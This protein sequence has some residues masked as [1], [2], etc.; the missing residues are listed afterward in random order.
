MY[1]WKRF[2]CLTTGNIKLDYGGFLE[3]PESEYA[4][5]TNSDVFPFSAISHIPCLVLLGEP[6]IGK[7]TAT[8]QAYEQVRD[9]VPKLKDTCLW[10]KLGDYESDKDLC[11]AIFRNET[12]ASW[13]HGNH[14]LHLF[15][16]SLDE[17][18]LS[19][20]ILIRILKR[21]IE[22][23]PCE[24]L[25]FRITCR[26]SVWLESSS[27]EQK[28]KEKW[29]KANTGIYE[30]APLRRKDVIEATTA[31]SVN[32]NEFIQEILDREATPL[33]IKPVTLKFL[34]STY[35][36]N[37]QLPPSQKELYEQGCLHLCEEVN[38][39]RRESGFKGKL[40]S[41]QRLI[42]AGR[43]A[44]VM[45]FANRAAIWTSPELA[46]MPNSAIAILDLCV[47]EESINQQEFL[48]EEDSVRE[49]LSITGLF[50]SRG[51]NRMGF[52]HQTYAE[53]LAAWYLVQHEIPLVQ[54]MSSVVSPEDPE[55]KLV[56]QLHE[57]A[58]WLAGMMPDVFREIMKADPDVL[59]RSDVATADVKDREALVENLLKL[60]DEEK[61]PNGALGN[62]NRYRKLEHPG[63]VE[64]L[65]PYIR[66][67]NKGFE[68]RYVAIDIAEACELQALQDD[69]ADVALDTSQALR[70]RL[71]AVSAICKIGNEEVK[72]RLKP[73]AIGEAKDN[74]EVDLK[75]YALQAVWPDHLKAEELFS[76][77]T[78]SKSLH[79]KFIFGDFVRHLQPVDLSLALEWVEK[80]NPIHQS[81]EK[82]VDAIMLK[83]WEHLESPGVLKALAKVA[84]SQL[85]YHDEIM[86]GCHDSLFRSALSNDDE[87]RRQVLEAMLS[88]LSNLES[89]L[90]LLAHTSTPII[91]SRDIPWL[92]ERLQA[93][94]SEQA[95]K[96]WA[97]LIRCVF[98]S[99]EQGHSDAVIVASQSN[100]IVAEAFELYLK[101]IALDSPQA[102]ELRSE[103]L[104]TQ[105]RRSRSQ[106]QRQPLLEPPPAERIIALLDDFESGNL[107]AWWD[108]PTQMMLRPDGT[109]DTHISERDLTGLP[110]WNTAEAKT[111]ARFVEAAKKYVLE[112]E[113]ETDSLRSST[114]YHS[115]LLG[116]QTLRLLLKEVPSFVSS[117]SV[118]V[119]KKW[120]PF[121][122]CY[123]SSSGAKEEE[124]DYHLLKMT[125]Q[126]APTE[127]INTLILLIDKE[128]EEHN[129]IFINCNFEGCWDERLENALLTK[130]KDNK[131]KPESMGYLLKYLLDHAVDKA[132][133]FAESIIPLQPSSLEEKQ[134]RAFV[135]ASVL[136]THAKD[137]GWSVVWPA[138]QQDPEFGRKVVEDV[139][140]S[141]RYAVNVGQALSED[142]LA[143]L[144]V[145]LVHQ[146][147]YA[148]DPKHE[149]VYSPG[150]RDNIAK[151]RNA[152]LRLLQERGTPQ[153]C[154]EIQEIINKLPEI[155]GLK[156]VLL[157]AQT[158][159]RRRTWKPP[160]P[161]EI[162]QLVSNKEKRLIQD[163]NELLDV[164][165]ESLQNLQV[166]LQGETPAVIDLWNEIKWGQIRSLAD[167]LVKY[168]KRQFGLDKF[169]KIDVWKEV[170]WR[171]ITDS[172]YL[173]KD[174]NRFSDYVVRYLK[175]NLKER[176]VIVNREVEI[177][178]G[179]RTDIQVDAVRKKPNGDVYDS[180]TVIIEVKGCW[181]DELNSAMEI[182]LVNRYLKDNTCQHGVYLV[183][184]FNCEQWDNSDSRKSKAPKISIDEAREKFEKQAEQLSQL[185]IKVKAFVL[186][187]ALR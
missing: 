107:T 172:A 170:N 134:A 138:I 76:A 52:A 39:D 17:G 2:W 165:L 153:A 37:G 84:L 64:Q 82:L 42:T 168:L 10:F 13:L 120:A 117:I 67:L 68:A 100:S 69:L 178:R 44:A 50:S 161:S 24:R 5:F 9:Q 30:L 112:E 115:S 110:G 15:L 179:E 102:Q 73:L 139:S 187:T 108:I 130:A 125:Y 70:I 55:R 90:P 66:D 151:W 156:R 126:Y 19:I 28:L 118:D 79:Q 92:T 1:K 53:F 36:K 169:A 101:P 147:P 4:R 83:A 43:I 136:I 33:A 113:L 111:R 56:P 158:L 171:K 7:T 26:T 58:A 57:T 54:V 16:D 93:S 133:A 143:N 122:L 3:D 182:Q 18:L 146:Y 81:F 186:N 185:G 105:R 174:E 157:E 145:W 21:E 38:L 25:Y 164:L 32:S 20:K 123:S 148:E 103:Y 46:E 124:L 34:L 41:H 65:R 22:N 61:L 175:N 142:Q 62:Y 23:L 29:E 47:G 94:E 78:P 59:L 14:K 77:L 150:P 166:T 160:L 80:Q 183:G 180:I 144:Y 71:N 8:K 127:I 163:G 162:L 132:K 119:W 181:N 31:N 87:K 104:E 11:N 121:I 35:R 98:S 149:G 75:H 51:A 48:I 109:Y 95:Q 27:L 167:S 40:N 116:Y 137:A 159:V 131:L 140:Y 63:L 154:E 152:V 74:S 89:D 106:N 114:C 99:N 177:R 96:T 128:N 184:W 176:G 49:V 135:A 129:R 72:A 88:I 45:L 60:Y 86:A 173:P 91:L 85:R 12:F 97:Q 155:D 141:D 6:G